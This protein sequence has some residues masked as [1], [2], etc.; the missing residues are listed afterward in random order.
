MSD[1]WREEQA[2]ASEWD[3][4]RGREK[5]WR[6]RMMA[7]LEKDAVEDVWTAH[8]RSFLTMRDLWPCRVV[9]ST[10]LGETV[11]RMARVPVPMNE[12]HV[13]ALQQEWVRYL[14][15]LDVDERPVGFSSYVVIFMVGKP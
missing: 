11:M 14:Y 6:G 3:Y 10:D 4:L 5:A 15:G 8:V 7:F 2:L 9:W 12:E 1:L 13:S